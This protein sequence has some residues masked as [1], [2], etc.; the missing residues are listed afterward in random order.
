LNLLGVHSFGLHGA[1][2]Y[3]SFLLCGLKPLGSASLLARCS[4]LGKKRFSL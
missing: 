1:L 4:D 3:L 2:D